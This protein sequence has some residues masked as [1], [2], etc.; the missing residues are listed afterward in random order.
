MR[1]KK[2]L[3]SLVTAG[4]VLACASA[5]AA[6][7]WYSPL[8]A[9]QDDNLDY[10]VDTNRNGTLDVGDRLVSVIEYVNS[11]GVLGGQGPTGF[12]ADEIT[13]VA[14]LTVLGVT[15]SGQLILGP[16]GA[17]GILSAFAPGTTAALYIDGSP[18]LNVINATCGTRANCITQATDGALLLTVGF[19]GD[20]D[21]SWV[22]TPAAGGTTIATVQGG[23]SST[24]FAAFS[25]AQSLGVNNTGQLFGLQACAPFCGI[26]GNGLVEVTGSGNILGGQFLDAAQWTARSDSDVQFAPIPEPGTIALMG[27]ALVGLGAV[28]RRQV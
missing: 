1:T 6:I 3:S 24:T 16:S 21:E 14:D 17:S 10:V 22:S 23:G 19:F 8:T 15:G 27:L 25:F 28:R 11:Q 13:G 2:L 7:T 5:S 26:G 12:G 18:N 4:L 20:A 9:L